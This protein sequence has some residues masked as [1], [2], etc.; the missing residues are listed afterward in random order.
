L[1]SVSANRLEWAPDWDALQEDHTPSVKNVTAYRLW[2]R[3]LNSGLHEKEP[4]N[5]IICI[6]CCPND[7]ESYLSPLSEDEDFISQG[8]LK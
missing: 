8:E 1:E 7:T 2:Q 4:A 6:N 5:R 3:Y